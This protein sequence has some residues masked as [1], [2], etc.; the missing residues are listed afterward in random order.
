MRWGTVLGPLLVAALVACTAPP[1][2][3]VAPGHAGAPGVR[4]VL[5]CAP[6]VA[7]ALRAEIAHGAVPVE[8]E[9]AAYLEARDLEVERLGLEPGRWHWQQATAQAKGQG[10]EDA[11]LTRFA[12]ALAERRDFDVLMMPSVVLHSVQVTDSSGTWDGV[13]RRVT[14]AN[15]P[16]MGPAGSTDTFT[17]GVAYGGVSGPVLATSLH[18]VVFSAQGQRVFE[19]WGGLEFVQEADL[20]DAS[21]Y[22]VN[23][24]VNPDA[25]RNRE[26]LREGV[27]IALAP[28][29]PPRD[30]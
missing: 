27:E 18:V 28:Y 6:N 29:F 16:S 17:K 5:L 11:A 8:R 22:R 3:F 21:T 26:V 23:F 19:G 20:S 1:R 7:V 13:R 15:T 25:F 12:Q 14:V 10:S 9:L 30:D 24:H 4:R 2:Y